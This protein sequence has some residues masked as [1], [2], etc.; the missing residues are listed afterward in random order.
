L[1]TEKTPFRPPN[2]PT[3]CYSRR[4]RRSSLA[5]GG[6]LDDLANGE[7]GRLSGGV[8]GLDLAD[9]G[10]VGLGEVVEDVAGLDGVGDDVAGA[11]GADGDVDHLVGVDQVEVLDLAVGGLEGGE[12]DCE[13]TCQ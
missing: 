10:V 2:A 1:R 13:D 4:T 6:Q 3:L 8:E 5:V 7:L 12:G 9:G 11:A